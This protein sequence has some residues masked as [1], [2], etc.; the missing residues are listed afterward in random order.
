MHP[1]RE[2][3]LRK[4]TDLINVLAELRFSLAVQQIGNLSLFR[5]SASLRSFCCIMLIL[6]H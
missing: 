2:M 4:T 1:K 6:G 3:D 5:R